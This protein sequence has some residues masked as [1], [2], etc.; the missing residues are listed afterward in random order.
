MAL[1]RNRKLSQRETRADF[2]CQPTAHSLTVSFQACPPPPPRHPFDWV[3]LGATLTLPRKSININ[4]DVILSLSLAI[5]VFDAPS[6]HSHAPPD[7]SLSYPLEGTV[8]DRRLK[9]NKTETKYEKP[10]PETPI[11]IIKAPMPL[12]PDKFLGI[13]LVPVKNEF[14]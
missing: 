11:S 14:K 4:L 9:F 6:P 1:H 5:C 12:D 13:R 8:F 10:P 3:C 2:L 7:S